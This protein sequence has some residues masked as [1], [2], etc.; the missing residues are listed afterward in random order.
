MAEL[1][2]RNMPITTQRRA[3]GLITQ[4]SQVRILSP[5]LDGTAPGTI[6]GGC[7]Y[8]LCCGLSDR[9]VQLLGLLHELCPGIRRVDVHDQLACAGPELRPCTVMFVVAFD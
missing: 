2:E 4:R 1:H 8:S 5:L 6:F 3:T 9:D 7:S